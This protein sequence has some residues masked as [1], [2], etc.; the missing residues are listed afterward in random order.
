MEARL[1]GVTKKFGGTVALR[2]V[3][4]EFRP[5][6]V[7]A[8]IGLNGAGKTTL[9]NLLAGLLVPSRGE[10]RFDGRAFGRDQLDVRRRMMFIPDVPVM[11]GD[12]SL[13]DHLAT[14]H[15]L[16]ERPTANVED[17]LVALMEDFDVLGVA[18]APLGTL[19]RG[20]IHKSGLVGLLAI[21][22][23][24]WL[25][26]EPFASG[27]DPHGLA[28]FRRH[29]QAAAARGRTVI[30]TTQILEVAQRFCDRLIVLNQGEVVRSIPGADLRSAHAEG[31]LDT[32]LE[33]FRETPAR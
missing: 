28:A 14:L 1:I 22:P 20:Q 12:E 19:S 17:R 31:M 24:L 8:L 21:D 18:R 6:E 27:M 26:D 30:Y 33:S 13:I 25:L 32:L 2:D 9:L 29:A 5:G 3:S 4:V 7:V 10:V 23:E 11:F 15:R 16:Y